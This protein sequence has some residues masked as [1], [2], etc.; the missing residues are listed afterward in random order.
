VRP[1]VVSLVRILV[2]FRDDFHAANAHIG[3]VVVGKS[4]AIAR[5][6]FVCLLCFR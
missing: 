3:S 5:R 4:R 6:G 2:Q 1:L